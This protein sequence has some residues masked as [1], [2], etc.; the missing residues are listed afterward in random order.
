M[1]KKGTALLALAAMALTLG[2]LWYLHR[3]VPPQEATWEDVQAEAARGGYRLITTEDLA[4]L[5]QQ[6]PGD[7]LLVDTRQLWEYYGGYIPGAVCFPMEPT[8]WSRWRSQGP[9]A[10]LLGPDKNRLVVFYC[11]GLT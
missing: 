2:L 6:P 11:A 10:E 3:P 1:P 9:L 5:C 4:K 7:F 8:W